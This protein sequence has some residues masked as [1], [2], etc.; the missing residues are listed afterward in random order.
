M[1]PFSVDIAIYAP[2]NAY[3]SQKEKGHKSMPVAVLQNPGFWR[4]DKNFLHGQRPGLAMSKVP[5]GKQKPEI[6][7]FYASQADFE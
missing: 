3:D 2:V 6:Y 7:L 4:N 5:R 1:L